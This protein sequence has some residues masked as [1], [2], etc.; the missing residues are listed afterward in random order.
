M[1]IEVSKWPTVRV[2]FHKPAT[3]IP[4]GI[5]TVTFQYIGIS[6]F[7]KVTVKWPSYQIA[8]RAVNS[9]PNVLV[10]VNISIQLHAI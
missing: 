9:Q 6:L 2:T 4:V 3:V 7:L 1:K 8:S 5:K 10:L